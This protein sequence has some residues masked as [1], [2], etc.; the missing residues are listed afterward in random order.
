MTDLQRADYCAVACAELFRGDGEIM[1]S[2]MAPSPMVGARLARA[3]F[4]PDLV[5]TDG[6]AA[7]LAGDLPVFAKPEPFIQEGWMPYRMVFD[8][9]WWGKRHVVMGASQIDKFGNQNISAIGD[10]HKP[11]S[12][13]LGVRGAPGNTVSHTTS[14]WV[15]RHSPRVFVD[16]VDVVSGVGYDRIAK[17]HPETQ[18]RHEIR[19]VVT[20]LGVF[21]FETEDRRMRVRQLHPGVELDEVIAQTGFELVIPDKIETT[22]PPTDEELR[23]LNEVID[24]KG[25]RFREVRV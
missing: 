22:R 13:L 8:T 25:V 6:V 1:A 5:L 2:P 12:Q 3:T 18:K 11:D 4:E 24:P 19:A 14:Y 23:L 17:L 10:F 20:N 21:D 9:L 7:I 16:K 15:A